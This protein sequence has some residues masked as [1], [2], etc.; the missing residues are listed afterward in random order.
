MDIQDT[1]IIS[2]PG[3]LTKEDLPAFNFSHIRNL[4]DR[5]G[6]I[7]HA[8]YDIP[9]RKEGYCIDDNSRALLLMVMAG[10]DPMTEN[11]RRLLPTYLGF[12]HYMQNESGNF[13][14]FMCYD[15]T[16]YEE[17]GSED[18]FG[19]TLM[20]LGYLVRDGIVESHIQAGKE[21][22]ERAFHHCDQLLS[23]RGMANSLIG[24]C[25]YIQFN[26]PDD[27]K[28]DMVTR[29]ADKMVKEFECN[30][31]EDWRWFEPILS[32]DNAILPMALFQAYE[33]TGNQYY[34]KVAVSSL[35]FLE[36]KVFHN[37]ML[38]PIGN[39]GWLVKGGEPARFDQQGIDAMA[40]VLC[41]SQV[42]KLTRHPHWLEKMFASHQW[43]L[44]NNDLGVSL[45]DPLT[46]GCADGL[47]EDGV[48]RNEGAESTLAYWISHMTVIDILEK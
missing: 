22:F 47:Q 25:Q 29:L 7:Q 14:N 27:M 30:A 45:Y 15:R 44:G 11:T 33:L 9:N 31:D 41:Y 38:R 16:C 2:K 43:F 40:M 6:I 28:K 46:G 42:Y 48:N 5:T 20:A 10:K 17:V 3:L 34:F 1:V 18:S 26:Q 23:I 39:Q 24:L 12:V 4:T 35:E 36:S 19:R 21:M 8:F 37:D 32:Y 13:R